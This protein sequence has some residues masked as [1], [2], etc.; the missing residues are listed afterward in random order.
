MLFLDLLIVILKIA[1][2]AMTHNTIVES[3][4]ARAFINKL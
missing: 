3:L 1:D 2:R 4:A